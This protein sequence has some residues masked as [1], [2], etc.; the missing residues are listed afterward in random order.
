MVD[1]DARPAPTPFSEKVGLSAVRYMEAINLSLFRL[2]KGKVGG[3]IFGV[4]V[5][6]LTA[7]GR[8]TGARYTKPLLALED[9][10]SWIVAGSRGG[11][12]NHPDWFENLMAFA[13]HEAGS[14]ALAPPEV[15]AAGREPVPV[16]AEV[17][18]GAV[19]DEWWARLVD[20]YSRF[21]SYQA[22]SPAREIPV[23]R[24]TP[25]TH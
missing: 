10:E 15:E 17:L 4:P 21:A 23:V 5:I 25:A 14:A 16:R 11:T 12:R 2:S 13:Q 9:G 7:S 20:V 22:R 24:L 8:T 1:L 6:L 19:R 3:T 18:E